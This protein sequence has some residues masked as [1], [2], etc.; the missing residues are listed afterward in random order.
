MKSADTLQSQPQ[1]DLSFRLAEAML[2]Y[3]RQV[4]ESQLDTVQ[5][6]LAEG[7]A[8]TRILSANP[9]HSKEAGALLAQLAQANAHHWSDCARRVAEATLNTQAQCMK[10]LNEQ[11]KT[12]GIAVALWG[13]ESQPPQVDGLASHLLQPIQLL[14]EM[15]TNASRP[16]GNFQVKNG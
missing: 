13:G 5:S 10:L 9:Q 15:L 16:W 6:L 1:I 7:A 4:L 8:T 2:A 12:H 11:T 3:A 14:M